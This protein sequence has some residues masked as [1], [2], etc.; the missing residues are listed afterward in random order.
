M[1]TLEWGDTFASVVGVG[2]LHRAWSI[3]SQSAHCH[4]VDLDQVD[5]LLAS[6]R[7][8]NLSSFHEAERK[9]PQV[10]RSHLDASSD[11]FDWSFKV[12]HTIF[13]EIIHQIQIKQSSEHQ[14]LG[15]YRPITRKR[16]N[17]MFRHLGIRMKAFGSLSSIK[18][19]TVF[20]IPKCFGR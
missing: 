5:A 3:S 14:L 1:T 18:T 7:A 4:I 6:I 11:Y 19:N 10:W 12:I 16:S 17:F 20:V 15:K 9:V 8:S 13:F 2:A